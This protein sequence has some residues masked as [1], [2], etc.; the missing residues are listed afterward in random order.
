MGNSLGAGFGFLP[1]T[2]V[3]T[4]VVGR[5]RITQFPG[6]MLCQN[7][8][9]SDIREIVR[10]IG[11]II[12]IQFG[13]DVSVLLLNPGIEL[14]GAVPDG[15]QFLLFQRR[16]AFICFFQK[17]FECFFAVTIFLNDATGKA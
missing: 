1:V 15:H 17:A 8:C 4:D 5:R 11:R 2:A 14:L 13:R 7:L 9:L 6:E 16:G 10:F 12:V 3:V